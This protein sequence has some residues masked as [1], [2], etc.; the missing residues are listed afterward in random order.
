MATIPARGG[1][2]SAGGWLKIAGVNCPGGTVTSKVYADPPN[3]TVLQ[4]ATVTELAIE[5]E[6]KA[7]YPIVKI[8]NTS[9]TL[10]QSVDGGHYAGA[11]A[12]TILGSGGVV[13]VAQTPDGAPGASDLVTLDYSAAPTILT[14]AFIGGYPGVQTELKAGDT[15]QLQ[16]TT[17]KPADAIQ[18]LDYEACAASVETFIAGTAFTVT[19]TIADRGNVVLARPARC[20]ARDAITAAYGGTRDTNQGGGGIDGQHVVNC[21][22][23]HP[24]VALGAIVYP[25]GQGALKGAEQATVQNTVLDFDTISY[26]SPNGDLSILS[27]TI[28]GSPKPATRVAGNYNVTVPNFRI[29]A[30]RAANAATTVG[31][32][33]VRIAHVAASVAVGEPYAR[34]RSGGNDGTA[35]Q[36][37]PIYVN[38][39]QE[40]YEAPSLDHQAGAGAWQGGGFT[41]GPSLWSRLL[42]VHDN[43]PK[44][45]FG[46]SNLSA[47]NLAGILTTTI[48]GD[49]TYT[50][51]GFVPRSLTFPAFSQSTTLN[52]AVVD[53]S[54]LSAGIF[55]A[56]NQPAVRHTP[57]G[58][59]G[60]AANEYTILSPLGT[61]PQTLWWNDVFAAG[62]NSSGT[63]QITLVQEAV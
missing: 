4:S 14:L 12:H 32:T 3:N 54:K 8:G 59:Q 6:V 39:D 53:Y 48:T 18:I 37:Y 44:G 52:V 28:Y 5:I 24:S 10:V 22:N 61:N 47:K 16:G 40:L 9:Y 49:A 50:L 20:R 60:D 43:D 35:A 15:F 26:S 42:R 55:T 21:N 30:V 2:A 11:L 27:P 58:D 34:L 46:W 29:T 13:V 7:A 62:A 38:S 56:T 63:A 57:Q 19:G 45:A 33:I 31:Q 25:V 41:G 17:N 36:D 1:G 51:G 23:L